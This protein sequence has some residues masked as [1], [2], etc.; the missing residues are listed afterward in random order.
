MRAL[1][2]LVDDG[3]TRHLGVSNFDVADLEDAAAILGPDRIVENQVRY[4]LEDREIEAET[5]PYCRNHGIAVVGYSPFGSGRFPDGKSPGGRVLLE[6]SGRLGK[7]PRQVALAFLTRDPSVFAIPKAES[8]PHV[9]E[10]AGA[11]FA[12]DAADVA[13]IDAAFPG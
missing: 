2:D 13:R 4:H 6:I 1:G 10:N 12:L 11:A 9:E 5:I 8:L 7:T 3:L